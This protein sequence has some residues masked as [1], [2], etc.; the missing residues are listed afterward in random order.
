MTTIL[1]SLHDFS[2]VANRMFKRFV[3]RHPSLACV[4]MFAVMP[5]AILLTVGIVASVVILPMAAI[6]GWL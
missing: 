6:G 2:T 5:V 4:L 3:D 1:H